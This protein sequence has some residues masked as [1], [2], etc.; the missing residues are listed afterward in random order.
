MI[1]YPV[2]IMY[3]ERL[4]IRC[5]SHLVSGNLGDTFEHSVITED[6]ST[7]SVVEMIV[8]MRRITTHNSSHILPFEV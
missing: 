5:V 6:T 3:C 2:Y 4:E 8:E 1:Y 7:S